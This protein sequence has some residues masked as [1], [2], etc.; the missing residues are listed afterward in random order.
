MVVILKRFVLSYRALQS[1]ER[2]R[3]CRKAALFTPA[4]PRTGPWPPRAARRSPSMLRT[5]RMR[6]CRPAATRRTLLSR[7]NRWVRPKC[8]SD[9]FCLTYRYDRD[10]LSITRAEYDFD[11]YIYFQKRLQNCPTDEK[12][13]S[14]CSILEC[15]MK[16]L[17]DR[18]TE[19]KSWYRYYDL[20]FLD[21]STWN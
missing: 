16:E 8:P 14:S 19:L 9:R 12:L 7:S 2:P 10:S 13:K 6:A 1:S 18:S 11:F 3:W 21:T 15:K 5:T 17:A 4:P 20:Y